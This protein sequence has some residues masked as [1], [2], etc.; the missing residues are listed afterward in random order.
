MLNSPEEVVARFTEAWNSH[1]AAALAALFDYPADFYNVVGR[2]WRSRAE[3][4]VAH[5]EAHATIFKD[6][7]L[8]GRAAAVR[9]LRPEVA[10]VHMV[11]RLSGE[12]GPRGGGPRSGIL[13]FVLVRDG[14]GWRVTT[15]HN[16]D[17][18]PGIPVPSPRPPD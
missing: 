10:T 18:M 4:Q 7:T 16:T 13:T 6:S 17:A 9:H 14:T 1:D 15:A 3:I 11:W 8:E 5:E 2:W 12:S